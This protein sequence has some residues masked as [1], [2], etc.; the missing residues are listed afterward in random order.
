MRSL[1]ALVA[2]T[3]IASAEPFE[4]KLHSEVAKS[5]GNLI[6]APASIG[7]A[8]AMTREG[9]GGDTAKEFDAVLGDHTKYRALYRSLAGR[10]EL[11]IANRLFAEA[12]LRLEKP[13]V[14]VTKTAYDAPVEALDF[15]RKHDSA[16]KHINAWVAKQT[17]D[18]IKDLLPEGA[19]TKLTRLV[20]VNAIH[21][22][23]AWV[24]PFSESS[25]RPAK[26]QVDAKTAK[27]V[28][29]MRGEM[30]VKL[31]KHGGARLIDLPYADSK[32]SL[33]IA[34]PD[35]SSLRDVERAYAKDGL[36]KFLA[37]LDRQGGETLVTLP[38]FK[39]EA[40]VPLTEILPKMGIKAAF[41]DFADF[42]A[43]ARGPKLFISKVV[44]KAVIEVNEKGTEA[45]AATAVVISTDSG[46]G[47]S[48]AVDRAF[49]FFLHDEAGNV[50]FAGRVTDP[51]R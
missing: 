32:L 44:H 22:K 31:G 1:A 9:A 49:A 4:A 33:L 20:L 37:A 26:F 6:Y 29:T 27:Q 3:S 15:G 14:D 18:K 38:K 35:G 39:I 13:F 30:T 51:T 23:A 34:V 47:R 43:I 16:R 11:A 46:P 24:E 50:L 5:E 42:K 36:G 21:F 19:I 25:T 10:P 17:K 8:L 28:P 48:F 45:A 12:S 2:L 40:D 7:I 41:S